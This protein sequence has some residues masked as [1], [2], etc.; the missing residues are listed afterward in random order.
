LVSEQRLF[1]GK[2]R[3]H[4]LVGFQLNFSN[5]LDAGSASTTANY[6]VVQPGKGKRSHPKSVHVLAAA[7]NA[8]N[9]SVMLTLGKFNKALGLN[10]TANDLKG[11]T[12]TAAGTITSKL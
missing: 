6:Q 10:L 3:K 2:G 9:N 1:T 5:A 8:A 7:Y 4:K 12:G 11:A